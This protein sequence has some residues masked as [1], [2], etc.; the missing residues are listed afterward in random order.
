[1]SEKETYS[2]REL[3]RDMATNQTAFQT[4]MRTTLREM[5]TIQNAN[6]SIMAKALVIAE[7]NKVDIEKHDGDI[8]SLKESRTFIKGAVWSGLGLGGIGAFHA[9]KQ[10][11]G[12]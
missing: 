9:I 11:F 5:N 12:W 8:N 6:N 2:T 1:M 10:W 3:I 7:L 4:E